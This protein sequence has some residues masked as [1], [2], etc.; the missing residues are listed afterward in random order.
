[1]RRRSLVA[2]TVL[3]ATGFAAALALRTILPDHVVAVPWT[4]DDPD[5]GGWSGLD[6]SFDG[7]GLVAVSDSGFIA[8]GH[9]QRAAGRLERAELKVF[10]PIRG[11]S[12]QANLYKEEDAEGIS[13][14]PGNGIVISYEGYQRV[15]RHADPTSRPSPILSARRFHNLP[16][17]RGLEAVAVDASGT[18][19]TLPE[20]AGRKRTSLPVFRHDGS[21]WRKALRITSAP[22]WLAVGADFGPDGLFYLLERRFVAGSFESRIRRFDLSDTVSPN[23]GEELYRSPPGRHGNLE[24]IAIWRDE[25]ARLRAVMIADDNFFWV[26]RS[27]IVEVT[28]TE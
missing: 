6:V 18:I 28:L 11:L 10:R 7:R 9:L 5:F 26:Q 27:Q 4:F 12:R 24:G 25:N 16:G 14:V 17:N 3:L 1:M 8:T 19:F 13:F 22:D 23:P 2:L 15:W 20:G 21:V